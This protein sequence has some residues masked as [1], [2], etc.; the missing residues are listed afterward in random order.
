MKEVPI[1]I[2]MVEDNEGDVL[3]TMEALKSAKVAN[4]VAVV[5]DGVEALAYLRRQGQYTAAARPDLVLLDLNL[6]KKDGRQVLSE[7][8]TDA[9]LRQ[10]PVV[11]LTSSAAEQDIAKAYDLNANCYVCKPVDFES[12]RSVVKSIEHFWFTVVKLPPNGQSR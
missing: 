5:P 6:P 4:C 8:K 7:I 2:L 9:E 11:V 12:L 1:Q 10:I 3:L